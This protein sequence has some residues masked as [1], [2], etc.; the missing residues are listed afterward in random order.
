MPLVDRGR[1][2]GTSAGLDWLAPL[3]RGGKRGTPDDERR[4][5]NVPS[6]TRRRAG[7]I[8]R[9][10]PHL[11]SRYRLTAESTE[12]KHEQAQFDPPKVLDP[13]DRSNDHPTQG[14]A[15]L[16]A[17]RRPRHF[18]AHITDTRSR[19]RLGPA[20]LN[21]FLSG[22]TRILLRSK[23]G[24]SLDRKSLS[25]RGLVVTSGWPSFCWTALF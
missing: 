16:A 19:P 15:P 20:H 7:P 21:A 24:P 6:T 10:P 14:P 9:A 17:T 12:P 13:T 1:F 22:R 18:G 3:T 4:C 2:S 8:C 25:A 11:T 5:A 23:R